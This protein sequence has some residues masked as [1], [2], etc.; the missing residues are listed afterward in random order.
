[1]IKKDTWCQL[2]STHAHLC[3][4]THTHTHIHT[5]PTICIRK[6]NN[7]F[8]FKID[9]NGRCMCW[10]V[11]LAAEMI[12]F[13]K[14]KDLCLNCQYPRKKLNVAMYSCNRSIVWQRQ[15]DPKDLWTATLAEIANLWF[16]EMLSLRE[17]KGRNKQRE[18]PN[19][20]LWPPHVQAWTGALAC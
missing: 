18:T 15:V 20:P 1:M 3:T 8:I 19:I 7:I 4:K 6:N 14:N 12:F 11:G 9:P 2:I 17:Q 13:Y 10:W 5:H 16:T